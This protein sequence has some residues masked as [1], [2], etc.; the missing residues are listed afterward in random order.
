MTDLS[1]DRPLSDPA[2]DLFDHSSFARSLA[3]AIRRQTAAEGIVLALFGPWGSGKSTV[4]AY[5]E[6]Y[7]EQSPEPERP[8]V[9]PFNPWWFSGQENLA[10]AFLSQLQAILPEKYAD[11][12]AIADKIAEFSEAIGGVVDVVATATGHRWLGGIFR[13]GAKLVARK[14]QDVP[15]LKTALSKL[16][17][18]Q[19]KRVL[20][21]V[22]DIDRLTPEEV[23]QLFTVIKALADFPY[24]TY[25][26]AFD[27]DVA[28][29]AISEQTGLPGER[30]L[31]KIIQV[32]FELPRVDRE[33]LRR[34]LF[35]RL[36]AAMPGTPDG[37]FDSSYWTNVFFDGLDPLFQVPRDIV[38]LTNS[39][40]VTYPAVVGEVN[41]VDFI[42]VECLRVFLPG[43]YDAVR[44]TP[45]QFTGYHAADYGHERDSAL[46]FH[47]AWLAKLPEALREST[48]DLMQRLF[49]RLESVWS[50]MHYS[51]ESALQWRRDLRVCSPEV[52]PT[53]FRLSLPAG[54]V[55]RAEV[56]A[57]LESVNDSDAF[58]VALR[59][60][61]RQK[62]PNGISKV[63]DLLERFLD[64]VPSDLTA[65]NAEPVIRALMMVGDE[66]VI[67]TDIVPGEFDF[68]NEARVSRI[69]YQLLKKCD[70][71][72]RLRLLTEAFTAGNALRCGELLFGGLYERAEEAA[73]GGGESP[74][75]MAEC[76]ELKEVWLRKIRQS[77]V[78]PEF[79]DH[80]S[81]ASLLSGWRR[82][83]G[84]AETAAWWAQAV[85]SD[86]GLLKLIASHMTTSTSNAFGEHALRVQIRVNPKRL[87][88]YADVQAMAMRVSTLLAEGVVAERWE[89]AARQFVRECD[90]LKEGKD[91]D[92][93]FAFDD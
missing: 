89:P 41:P 15:A 58:T 34:A 85:S 1:S 79:I 9:V 78:A 71:A 91:P 25:L 61:A 86:D 36:D 60:A 35:V 70:A 84:D 37:R 19:R 65:E 17:R 82:W 74:L 46:A 88:P 20:V 12:K 55:S 66:L 3:N 31:E 69:V 40:S 5:V 90:M 68:G 54:A 53:Y 51:A 76:T 57:M 28:S 59:Q 2:D 30:Y 18:E 6:H 14:P 87:A 29:A 63:R 56:D 13:S 11:F 33:T 67:P 21:I 10:K 52:F 50:N 43:A 27:R 77:S 23:R 48:K 75:T 80:P 16:L 44:T 7:L 22:D 93:P 32:P 38:R 81:I 47:N 83:G 8:V 72:G 73:K 64:H 49:P 4:L 24:V 42:A 45:E 92:A 39:L 62:H 26:L